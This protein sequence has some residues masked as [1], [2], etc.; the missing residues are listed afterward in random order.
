MCRFRLERLLALTAFF[1]WQRVR[2]GHAP[3]SFQ[4]VA[5]Y[6]PVMRV[7]VFVRRLSPTIVLLLLLLL[8]L[9]VCLV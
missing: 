6:L 9:L 5:A 8:H 7:C 3:P 4:W 2:S 1:S